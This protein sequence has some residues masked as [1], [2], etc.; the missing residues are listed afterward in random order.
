MTAEAVDD[1]SQSAYRRLRLQRY[2]LTASLVDHD[3]YRDAVLGLL[4]G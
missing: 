4:G 2:R 3:V 1:L